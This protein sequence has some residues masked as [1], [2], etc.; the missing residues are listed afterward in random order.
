M[1]VAFTSDNIAGASDSV[2]AA[3]VKAAQ[4]NAMPYGNDEG[5]VQVT[6]MLADLFECEVDVFL[7]S[8]GTAA[9]VLSLSAMTPQWGNVFCHQESHLLNDESSA[10]EFFTGGAR[11]VGLGGA[12][13]KI[14]PLQLRKAATQKIGDVHTCQPGALSLSQVTEVGSVYSL[15]EIK[16][17]TDIA[18]EVGIAT[19][20]DGARFANALV[21][22]KCSPAEMTW[23]AGIDI[24]SFG[25]TKNGVMA[26]EAIVV[27]NRELVKNLDV[28]RKR[29][30]HLHSK[31]RLL[32][33]QMAAYL[34][35]EL[36]LKNAM[37]ANEMMALMQ[38]GLCGIPEI[39]INTPAQANMLFCTLP[40]GMEDYLK[41]K[42]F[43]FYG[44]RWES[45][46]VRLVTSFRTLKEDVE[47]FVESARRFNTLA[48]KQSRI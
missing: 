24:V 5:T 39:K 13:A 36:W 32:S 27:F 2:L 18:K 42:G 23:K 28:L 17:L 8:T 19:H 14:D 15:E 6:N 7:V 40:D 3:I 35:D 10:P 30:G 41:S 1:N 20:M 33:S 22:L 31:M 48:A 9:N 34:T 37:H 29:G 46:V 44:G 16:A 4:G 26:A 45:G 47:A 25:A 11:L 43:A 38:D 21:A 12:N